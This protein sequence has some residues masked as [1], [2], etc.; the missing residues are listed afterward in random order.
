M[1]S[2]ASVS[3]CC[4]AR[5]QTDLFSEPDGERDTERH[6]DRLAER[7]AFCDGFERPNEDND[8]ESDLIAGP[9]ANT[10]HVRFG[11]PV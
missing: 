7:V 3:R 9:D 10:D 8:G 2:A 1:G 6:Q 4:T 11:H 5:D